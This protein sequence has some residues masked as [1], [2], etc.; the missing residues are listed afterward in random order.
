MTDA[1]QHPNVRRVAQAA[2]DA[3]Q[4]IEV[5]RFAS[6]TR[7]AEDAARA[8]GCEVA[9]IVKSLVFLADGQAVVALVSGSDRLDPDRLGR[10]LGAREVRRADGDEVRAAT[11]YPI[12]GVPPFAHATRLPV[13]ID[14]HL[15]AHA[16]VW[17]AAGLPDVVFS[18]SPQALAEVSGAR[19]AGVAAEPDQG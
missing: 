2:A 19:R 17:A 14:E 3:G 12:G 15:F 1:D 6:G 16:Q 18:I 4:P 10:A 8:V 5:Q 11:G 9:Q 7:T 13:V